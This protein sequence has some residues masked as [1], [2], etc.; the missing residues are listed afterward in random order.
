MKLNRNGSPGIQAAVF[1]RTTADD[2]S[3]GGFAAVFC[4]GEAR[5]G[6]HESA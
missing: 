5:Q 2:F 4:L 3:D 6:E 1:S